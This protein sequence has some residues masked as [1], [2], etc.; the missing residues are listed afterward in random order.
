[1]T[2]NNYLSDELIYDGVVIGTGTSSEPVIYHLSKTSLNILIIDGSD[3]YKD[4]NKICNSKKKYE[5][6]F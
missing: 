4:Y 5:I 3:L 2:L 6:L 1:M